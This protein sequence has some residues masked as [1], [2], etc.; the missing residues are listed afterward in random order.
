MTYVGF[1]NTGT[2][3]KEKD[4]AFSFV[5]DEVCSPRLRALP[6]FCVHSCVS[7]HQG[8]DHIFPLVIHDKMVDGALIE[9]DV[10]TTVDPKWFC[11]VSISASLLY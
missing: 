3:M 6:F 4:L 11:V 7:M 5:L 10:F 1:A 9:D 2:A 8:L